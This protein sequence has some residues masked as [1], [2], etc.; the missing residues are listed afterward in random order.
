MSAT[1]KAAAE[2][3]AAT[4]A[5]KAKVAGVAMLLAS[6][7]FKA[8]SEDVTSSNV[9]RYA[10]WVLRELDVRTTRIDVETRL[11]W[12]DVKSRK[13]LDAARASFELMGLA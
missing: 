9:K 3:R 11:R 6:L 7:G 10:A 12:S 4:T 13:V 8:A 2:L 5:E 1:E